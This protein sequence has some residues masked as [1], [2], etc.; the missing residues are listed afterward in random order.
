MC[1]LSQPSKQSNKMETERKIQT[2]IISSYNREIK[3]IKKNKKQI[4]SSAP[5]RSCIIYEETRVL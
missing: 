1:V 2:N 5:K 3:R 4:I